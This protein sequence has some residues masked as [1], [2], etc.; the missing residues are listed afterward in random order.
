MSCE[1]EDIDRRS[2]CPDSAGGVDVTA[3][4]DGKFIED[5]TF[6]G[7]LV[8]NVTLDS[9]GEF[10]FLYADK[11]DTSYFNST[12]ERPNES[13]NHRYND[14]YFGKF[15]GVDDETGDKVDK[16]A[17]CCN[18]VAFH[19]LNNGT[20]R[21]QGIE[22]VIDPPVGAKQWRFSQRQNKATINVMSGTGAENNRAE[23]FLKSVS[24]NLSFSDL[25][26]EDLEAL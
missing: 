7:N 15:D 3:L 24:R 21:V 6:N 12:G 11:D 18:V 14:E 19:F 23:V 5:L 10:A 4:I 25:S 17:G 20:C 2:D 9:A 22:R 1:I 8:A 16:L 26:V 13:N